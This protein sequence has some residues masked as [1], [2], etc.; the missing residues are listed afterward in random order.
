MWFK[1]YDSF[2][3]KNLNNL[4]TDSLDKAVKCQQIIN[5]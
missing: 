5:L 3:I 4:N 1:F 2:S